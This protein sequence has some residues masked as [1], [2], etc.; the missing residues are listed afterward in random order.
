V[1]GWDI[2]AWANC[3]VGPTW[4]VG[5]LCYVSKVGASERKRE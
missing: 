1:G 2:G 3:G 4:S 5:N